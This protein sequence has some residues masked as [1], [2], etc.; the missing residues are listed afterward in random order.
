METLNELNVTEVDVADFDGK[1]SPAWTNFF[2]LST[3]VIIIFG[4][5]VQKSLF[6]LLQRRRGRGINRIIIAQQVTNRENLK[7]AN[8]LIKVH[9]LI[10]GRVII[11]LRLSAG[12][13]TTNVRLSD[14]RNCRHLGLPSV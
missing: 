13:L 7:L 12:Q 9:P 6:K 1:Y 10:S 8:N 14:E 2:T 4:I 5:C 11:V 3:L